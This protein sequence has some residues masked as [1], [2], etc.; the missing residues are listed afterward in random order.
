MSF[1][2]PYATL[3]QLK[4]RINET[5]TSNDAALTNALVTASQDLEG[6]LGRQFNTTSAASL[7][8]GVT[9]SATGLVDP[10]ANFVAASVGLVVTSGASTATITT[11][12]N[13]T[14]LAMS[15]GWTGGTPSASAAYSIPPYVSARVYYPDDLTTITFED[16][17]T[18]TGLIV[19]F[20]FSN[21]GTYANIITSTNYQ[22]EP[23]NGVMDGTPGWPFYRLHVIQTWPPLLW[24]S[25][26]YPRASVQITAQWGWSAVPAPVVEA[27]LMLAEETF[28][29]KDA[30][31]GVSAQIG[32]AGGGL[33]VRDNPK[34]YNLVS[35]YDRMPIKIA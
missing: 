1:G 22:L 8:V 11:V 29:M 34:I 35:R 14:T 9:Y 33:R 20:D 7:G 13:G 10:S 5:T 28:K 15:G 23:L 19:A 21:S 12:T 31:F 18:T 2:D 26:G 24:T 6:D 17:A 3:A 25:I 4:T 32:L 16:I 30:P 27:C